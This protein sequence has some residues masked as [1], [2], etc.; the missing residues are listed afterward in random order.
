MPGP[1]HRKRERAAR[2]R[3]FTLVELVIVVVLVAVLGAIAVPTFLS[4]RT[5]AQDRDAMSDVRSA[6]S[7]VEA[8]Y[9]VHR[10]YA[11]A[12]TRVRQDTSGVRF[13]HLRAV[14]KGGYLV[15]ARSASRDD[16]TFSIERRPDGTRS[17][18]CEAAGTGGCPDDHDWNDS[19]AATAQ[20]SGKVRPPALERY[21]IET[22]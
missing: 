14:P 20:G 12:G 17:Y 15:T 9:A 8:W 3:R 1:I 7:R 18:Y 22:D 5:D 21:V 11:G 13:A 4:R 6:A 16:A 2:L 19:R 10:S